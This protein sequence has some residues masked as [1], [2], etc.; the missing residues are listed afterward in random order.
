M[1]RINILKYSSIYKYTNIVILFFIQILISSAGFADIIVLKTG[2]KIEGMIIQQ[3][4]EQVKIKMA[5]GDIGY[6]KEDIET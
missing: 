1:N 6:K 2:L 3:T 4:E 5:L